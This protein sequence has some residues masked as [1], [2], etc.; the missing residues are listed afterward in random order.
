MFR[1]NLI[2]LVQEVLPCVLDDQGNH[3]WNFWWK[4]K[5][6]F[7]AN[8]EVYFCEHS[9]PWP[10]A[11]EPDKHP[12]NRADYCYNEKGW[13]ENAMKSLYPFQFFQLIIF[14]SL[15]CDGGQTTESSSCPQ[16]C[17]SNQFWNL[18]AG[19]LAQLYNR[20]WNPSFFWFAVATQSDKTL[21]KIDKLF[22]NWN[23]KFPWKNAKIGLTCS[24]FSCWSNTSRKWGIWRIWPV[25]APANPGRP[26]VRTYVHPKIPFWFEPSWA[27]CFVVGRS[28]CILLFI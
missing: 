28:S 19:I 20:C 22:E 25:N 24:I 27:R 15:C 3:W 14:S 6:K 9:S 12:E 2:N 26:Y 10:L 11:F 5:I 21:S 13:I 4:R 8:C 1:Y 23:S 16:T 7:S 17:I 18:L